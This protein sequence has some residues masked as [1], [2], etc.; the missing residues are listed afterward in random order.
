MTAGSQVAAAGATDTV[1]RFVTT[2]AAKDIPAEAMRRARSALLDC[3]GCA[4]AGAR[5][6]SSALLLDFIRDCGGA[7]QATVMGTDLRTSVPDAALANGMLSSALLYEDTCLIMPGHATATLLPVL[8]ALGESRHLSG[9][10]VLE[11]Y[12]VGFELE[13]ALGPAIAPDHYERGWHATAT[14]GTM[15]A[16]AAACRLLGLDAERV[17]MALGIATS[18][19]AGSRQNFGAM[20]QA[21]HSGV[22]ARNGITAALLAQR[23][24]T[25]DPAILEARMG[26][27]NLYGIGTAKLDAAMAGLGRE[28]ALLGPNLYMKLHPCGFPLQ[29]P[30][31]CAI[32]LANAHD[33]KPADIEEIHCGVH[34]LIP[35]TVFHI[36][37]QT[38]LQGRTSIPYCVARAIIDRHMG[39]AQFTDEKVQ[40]PAVRALMPRVKTVVPPELSREAL[41]GRVNAIAAPAL[42]EIRLRDGRTV[43]TRV[44]QFRGAGER[45]FTDAELV[46]KFRECAGSVLDSARVERVRD[47]IG[48]LGALQDVADLAQLLA[49]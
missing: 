17:R 2:I 45:P 30:I 4:I 9:Q 41:R 23:G 12:V 15:G 43:S 7:P 18:L 29:R 8:L 47:M 3:I 26:F 19:A 16:T 38:G 20:M 22:A 1:A 35:E 37:P 46:G 31:D 28:F 40:D 32:E 33:L 24:F 25:A 11:A 44:E 10:A 21:F 5:Y 14:V 42:M 48:N 6:A 34:Y 13:A 27:C 36:N 49:A 39:L